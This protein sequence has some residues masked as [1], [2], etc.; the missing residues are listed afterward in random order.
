MV[1]AMG[2]IFSPSRPLAGSEQKNLQ[3]LVTVGL[4]APTKPYISNLRPDY[5]PITV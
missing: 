1:K 2:L 5:C 3:N 4:F